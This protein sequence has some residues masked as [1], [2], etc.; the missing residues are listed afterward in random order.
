M[1]CDCSATVRELGPPNVRNCWLA[2]LIMASVTTDV[3]YHR[4]S[5]NLMLI[6]TKFSEVSRA[7]RGHLL[8]H[9]ALPAAPCCHANAI[10][11]RWLTFYW[12]AISVNWRN[13]RKSLT[14]TETEKKSPR[15]EVTVGVFHWQLTIAL[16]ATSAPGW[17]IA[18]GEQLPR[19]VQLCHIPLAD[20]YCPRRY[21]S[22]SEAP[23]VSSRSIAP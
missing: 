10:A 1:L 21:K 23:L 3:P 19:R 18:S 2:S 5:F 13:L 7:V 12:A 16:K 17:T 6:T 11:F 8:S 9:V 14:A 20:G 15:G 22:T 4:L